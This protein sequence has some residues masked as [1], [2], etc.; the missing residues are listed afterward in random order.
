V[1]NEP[2]RITDPILVIG[3]IMAVFFLIMSSRSGGMTGVVMSVLAIV[4]NTF[5]FIY[6][7]TKLKRKIVCLS[8][9]TKAQSINDKLCHNCGAPFS[10]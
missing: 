4:A 9:G 8:C 10:K 3:F 2:A 6:A 1:E 7:V 5:V